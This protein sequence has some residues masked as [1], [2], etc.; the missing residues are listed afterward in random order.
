MNLTDLKWK[1]FFIGGQNGIF[2]I[3]STSSGIDKN[4]LIFDK[5][6]LNIPYITRSETDNGINLFISAKQ[7][8]KYSIDEGNVITIGL[9]TQTVFYQPYKFFT[10]QN[11]QVLRHPKL[12]RNIALF[13]IPLIKKQME[14]FNW[15]GNGATLGRL[16]RSKIMLPVNTN[17]DPDWNYMESYIQKQYEIKKQDYHN[18]VIKMI[19]KLEYKEIVPLNKKIWKKF[20]LNELFFIKSGVRLTKANMT[21]GKRPFIGAI[22]SNNGITHFVSN[23]NNSLD[24]NVLGV[25]Y[26][27]SVCE[28]FYHPYE[29]IFTDDVKHLALK[30]IEGNKFIYLFFKQIIFK[31]KIKYSYGYKFNAK[32]ME[33]QIV[34]VPVNDEEEPDFK[35][36]EQYI[37]N[38]MLIKYKQYLNE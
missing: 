13:I 8:V 34:L 30:D 37:K 7:D 5:S 23:T 29:C 3:T 35:Y 31:Q 25:N 24:R 26:N 19:N 33:R 21:S 16:S 12:N 1:E 27:G 11:I 15:G 38:L 36:M 6:T 9:D 2:K 32:R 4:K 10:G 17:N 18:Y 14:K 28:V 22:D 20:F